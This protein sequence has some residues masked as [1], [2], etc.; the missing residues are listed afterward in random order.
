MNFEIFNPKFSQKVEKLKKLGKNLELYLIH[1]IRL[2]K[3]VYKT[4]L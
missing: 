1:I 4:S 2:G 3:V